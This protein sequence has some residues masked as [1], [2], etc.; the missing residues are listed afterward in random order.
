MWFFGVKA[1]I[2]SSRNLFWVS[3]AVIILHVICI[4]GYYMPNGGAA[5]GPRHLAPMQPF[6]GIATALGLRRSFALGFLVGYYSLLLTGV[7]TLICAMPSANIS[8]PLQIFYIPKLVT[9]TFASTLPSGIG[10][11]SFASVGLAFIVIMWTYLSTGR[12]LLRKKCI[13]DPT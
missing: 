12:I 9:A 2:K 13:S 5:L 7:A 6:L 8:L 10:L 3:T 11:S 1:F 4:S